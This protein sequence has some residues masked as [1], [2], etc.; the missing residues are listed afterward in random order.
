MNARIPLNLQILVWMTRFSS[1]FYQTS[2]VSTDTE[3]LTC[4]RRSSF[5]CHSHKTFVLGLSFS[6]SVRVRGSPWSF[7]DLFH[8]GRGEATPLR[9]RIY[10]NHPSIIDFSDAESTR[11]QLDINLLDGQ[12]EVTEYPLRVAAFTNINSLSLFFVRPFQNPKIIQLHNERSRANPL[13]ENDQGFSTWDSRE[14]QPVHE[15]IPPRKSTCQRPMPLM[16]R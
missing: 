11:P 7:L 1:F 5:T 3:K 13:G 16:R 4:S 14:I 2:H 8:L 15:R 12:I 10:A 9:L 6:N